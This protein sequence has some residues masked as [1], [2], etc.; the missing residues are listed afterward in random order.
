MIRQLVEA[1]RVYRSGLLHRTYYRSQFYQELG[2]DRFLLRLCSPLH[3]VLFGAHENKNPNP[4]FDTEYYRDVNSCDLKSGL[5]PL[6][7]YIMRGARQKR[8]PSPYFDTGYYL[9]TNAEVGDPCG[10]PLQHFFRHGQAE[11]RSPSPLSATIRQVD[12]PVEGRHDEGRAWLHQGLGPSGKSDPSHQPR[13]DRIIRFEWDKGGWNNIRMQLEVMVCMAHRFGRSLVLPQ[14]GKWYLVSGEATHLYDFFDEGVFRAA[15]SVAPSQTRAD[16]EWEVP[17]RL[18]AT[19]T[20]RLK[21]NEFLEQQNRKSWYFPRST[22]MFGCMGGILGSSPGLYSL[23]HKAL[24]IR[25]DILNRAAAILREHDLR[26]GGFMAAHV[27]RGDF[28]YRSMRHL[29][30]E[31]VIEAL[32]K[33]GADAVKTLLIVSDAYDADLLES[34]RRQGWKP[35]CWAEKQ[36]EDARLSGVLDMLCCCLGW[37]FVG[38]RLSTF[39]S[40]IMQWRGYVSRDTSAHVDA[41]PRFTAEIDDVPW[42]AMV[43]QHAW[44]AI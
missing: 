40:G 6:V 2:A 9:D 27:R 16:D 12:R 44:L 13:P 3:F 35:I 19:N 36:A 43:D 34:C 22:R 1:L 20:A 14:A 7:H 42:W 5:N 4:F 10:N 38:T 8:N 24:R 11:G 29:S 26:P 31:N 33:H 25:P 32:R 17:A 39:S 28:Q 30:H 41:V 23:V 21:Q 37:R 18:G 15:L